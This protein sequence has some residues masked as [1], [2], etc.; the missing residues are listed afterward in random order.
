MPRL[1]WLSIAALIAFRCC[2]LA[3]AQSRF[4]HPAPQYGQPPEDLANALVQMARAS[5]VPMVAELVW[6]LPSIP[7][8]EG[9]PL[10]PDTL[11]EL[12]KQ[13]P[14]YEWKMEGKA[15]H[16]YNKKLRQARFNFLNLKIPRFTVP[17]DLSMLKLWFPGQAIGLLEGY[18]AQGGATT[19]FGDTLLE[20]E[21]LQQVTLENVT[22]LE[23]LVHLANESPTFY[24]LLVFS[25]A[26]PTKVEAKRVVW[27]WGSLSEKLGPIY[28]QPP[29]K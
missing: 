23:V 20:K 24:T 29:G 5:H 7:I 9:K 26:T 14:G 22:P 11:N 17:A 28:T 16:F 3:P 19:G 13:S 15:V 12:V 21:K 25:S 10:N 4:Q 6:P 1:R 18:T 2:T 8:A 27:Q